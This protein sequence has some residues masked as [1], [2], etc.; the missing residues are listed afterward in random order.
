MCVY[1]RHVIA[2]DNRITRNS[3]IYTNTISEELFLT[4]DVP[5][6]E[7]RFNAH[8]NLNIWEQ[9]ILL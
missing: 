2:T 9:C 7:E 1:V 3:I 5:L 4:R 6:K 8:Y